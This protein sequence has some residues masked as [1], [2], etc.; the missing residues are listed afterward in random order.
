MTAFDQ[1]DPFEHRIE[2]ALDEIAAP[3]RPAYLDD[4]LRQTAR[5]PQ[6]PRWTFPERWFPMASVASR[7]ARI[8]PVP[9]RSLAILVV[10][11]LLLAALAVVAV[12]GSR[13]RLP[14]PFGVAGNGSLTYATNGDLYVRDGIAGR[15]RLLIGG[16]GDQGSP[17][18][19]P[20]G[21]RLLYST[22][23]AGKEVG[24]IANADGSNPVRLLPDLLVNATA[25]WSPDSRS[26]AVVNAVA[27]VPSLYIVPA[28][29]SSARK[30][31]LGGLFAVDANWRPDGSLILLR[32]RD[33]NEHS[34]LYTIRPDGT[35]L[36]PFGL[37]GQTA[38]GADYTLSGSTWSP[39]GRTIAYNAIELDAATLQTHFRVHVI[40]ADGTGDR[41]LPGPASPSVQEAWP[42][43]SPDGRTV[44][45]HEWTWK[46]DTTTPE[47]WVAVVAAD[48][49]SP[50]R[51]IGPR[52]PGGEDT[53][54]GKTW[55]PDGSR[56]LLSASNTHQVWSVDPVSGASELLPWTD[57]LPDWQRVAP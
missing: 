56:I 47:G 42:Q 34:D 45:V 40:N 35:G 4:I 7:Q 15:P 54:L 16:D 13:K 50:V 22:V 27:G 33:S 48:G 30:V 23:T 3:R 53:G 9:L 28:D 41:E 24:M 55:S 12:T 18:Y 46:K 31:D 36:H 8:G 43:F 5:S 44:L 10:V 29:G 14:A 20:D 26:I 52:V 6:R 39:D 51:D 37:P 11:A 25:S 57:N 1:F 38:F 2:A 19:S 32:A 17:T 49:S 21:Q